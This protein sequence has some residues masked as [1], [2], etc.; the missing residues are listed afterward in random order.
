MTLTQ[1]LGV[2]ARVALL[3]YGRIVP[4]SNPVYLV[5]T[6]PGL[7]S[8]LSRVRGDF[9]L[10]STSVLFLC[11]RGRGSDREFG[12]NF[13]FFFCYEKLQYFTCILYIYISHPQIN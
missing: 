2:E 10:F 13:F 7:D 6:K 4:F 11:Q 1:G 5:Q 12:R 8:V 3:C 9:V